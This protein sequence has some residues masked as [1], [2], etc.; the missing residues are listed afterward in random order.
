[1][2]KSRL[3]PDGLHQLP[4]LHTGVILC[5]YLPQIDASPAIDAVVVLTME[6]ALRIAAEWEQRYISLSSDLAI[7]KKYFAIQ[8]LESPKFDNIFVQLGKY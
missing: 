4:F 6:M 7:C 2:E 3:L 8:A 1:M 5:Q